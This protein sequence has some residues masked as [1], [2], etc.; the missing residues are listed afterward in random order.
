MLFFPQLLE[1]KKGTHQNIIEGMKKN[2]NSRVKINGV[3]YSL[4]DEINLD[5]NIKHNI[6]AVVDRIIIKNEIKARLTESVELALK[7]S[8][9]L[10]IIEH[11][12]KEEMFST[13]F[14]CEVCG[15][16]IEEITPRLFSFNSPFG[17]C[18]KCSGLGFT[19]DIDEGL[20]IKD[21]NLSVNEGAFNVT[22]WNAESGSIA[23]MYYKALSK[24]Y[25]ID[26]NKPIK[27]L[28]REHLDIFLY[29]N[30]GEKLDLKFKN[31]KFE[32]EYTSSFEGLINN[33]KRRYKE[34][35]SEYVRME[36]A[37]LMIEQTCSLCHGKRL[38]Q[39]ALSIKINGIDIMELCNLSIKQLFDF[40]EKI[41]LPKT[42]MIIA[43]SILKE[44]KARL[45]FLFDVG[46]S[47]LTL[48][49]S[50]E[51]LSGGEAQRIRLATQIGSGL[52]GVLY[53]LDEPSI[54]LHQVDNRKLLNTL[55][56]LRDLQN[57]LIVVEHDEETIRE[58]DFIVDICNCWREFMAEKLLQLGLWMTLLVQKI[59]LLVTIFLAEK[60]LKFHRSD[61][62]RTR[63]L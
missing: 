60:R 52:V 53:I 5:K 10:V 20:V 26:L 14:S 30:K 55:K 22:G 42:E 34:T 50:A 51:S 29:G 37:R 2:G 19:M 21:K 23:S 33:L 41:K 48:S 27:D 44:I 8:D 38:K 18:P 12:E 35:T 32:G 15:Y 4:D 47:Y 39:E 7:M 6:Y 17:A 31:D 56:N 28:K 45:K 59:Q 49:R 36:I 61:K 58:A 62:N 13:R 57:T 25:G 54:G 24:K 46:L 43:E 1:D 63:G 40:F 11:G 16:S 9:G 3:I